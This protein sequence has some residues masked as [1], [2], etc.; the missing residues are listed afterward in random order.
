M[1]MKH[2]PLCA[3][4]LLAGCAAPR[5]AEPPT[6]AAPAA[7]HPSTTSSPAPAAPLVV[8]APHARP[9]AAETCRLP[10]TSEPLWT[11]MSPQTGPIGAPVTIV[12]FFDLDDP[13]TARAAPTVFEARD[14]AGREQ[15][16]VVWRHH[17]LPFHRTARRAA[18]AAQH[19]FE[20][21][22]DEAFGRFIRAVLDA[23]PPHT[24]ERLFELAAREGVGRA[25]LAAALDDPRLEAELDASA[26]LARDL[27][28]LGTPAFLV[29]GEVIN[30]AQPIDRFRE[31]LGRALQA[32]RRGGLDACE[33]TRQAHPT[34]AEQ[35]PTAPSPAA[36]TPEFVSVPVG[37]SPARG[38]ADALVTIVE[39]G[40]Y[41]DPFSRKAAATM[42]A[43]LAERGGDVRHVWKD[44][45]LPFH[46]HAISAAALVRRAL[47]RGGPTAFFAAHDELMASHA[48]DDATLSSLAARHRL[49][50]PT[51]VTTPAIEADLALGRAAGVRGTPTFFVN[52]RRVGGARPKA[53]FDAVIDEELAKAKALLAR[54]TPRAQIYDAALRA[55]GALPAAPKA[56]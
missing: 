33:A 16:R 11:P 44:F 45:P 43:L 28:L 40:G 1:N 50:T 18:K 36:D 23:R 32:S 29:N 46:T 14:E 42:K 3:L 24:D 47:A 51:K 54:G 27:G 55:N 26:G 37:A 53:D 38:P 52:G 35:R 19:V 17:P 2:L 12:W 8:A 30:G 20:Q 6:V 31:V 4:A 5:P 10:W 49:G 22:G 41:Q 56:P 34:R 13:F 21:R 48:V 39:F 15:V 25:D 7:A 9:V